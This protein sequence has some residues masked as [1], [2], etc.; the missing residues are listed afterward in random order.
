MGAEDEGV[1]AF[2]IFGEDGREFLLFVDVSVDQAAADADDTV[3][4]E[5]GVER[6]DGAPARD[7]IPRSRRIDLP[8]AHLVL[9]FREGRLLD[10]A[11]EQFLRRRDVGGV[12]RRQPSLPLLNRFSFFNSIVLLHA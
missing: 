8:L 4:V 11:D 7:F 2:V 1:D 9:L 6:V 10:G 12:A 3:G 5:E